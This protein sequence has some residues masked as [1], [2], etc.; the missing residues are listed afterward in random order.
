MREFDVRW[1]AVLGRYYISWSESVHTV[2]LERFTELW[3]M[4][5]R[6]VMGWEWG[7]SGDLVNGDGDGVFSVGSA[8]VPFCCACV[9]S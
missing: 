2:G 6:F 1:T 9:F 3:V 8:L 4:C 5:E 7:L